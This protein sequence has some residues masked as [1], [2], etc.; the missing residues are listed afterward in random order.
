MK[1]LK[2]SILAF[3]FILFFLEDSYANKIYYIDID[4]I[5]KNSERGKI[6]I[7]NLE[8]INSKNINQLKE[9]QLQ[10]I[11]LEKEI[12]SKKNVLNEDEINKKINI[13]NI[14]VKEFNIKKN[15]INNEYDKMK[16]NELNNFF[17]KVEKL[18]ANY[19]KE[20]SID[21]LIDKKTVF[22]GISSLDV[23]DDILS[24]VNNNIK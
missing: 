22:V 4:Y 9:E 18:I 20:K 5:I 21:L 1:L 2:K 17:T 6:I 15:K 13:L 10:L 12:K 11:N 8:K 3:F 24:I 16:K 23:T 7:E 14:K 19:V